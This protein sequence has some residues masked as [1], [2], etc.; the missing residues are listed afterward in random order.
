MKADIIHISGFDTYNSHDSGNYIVF[1]F[2]RQLK[3][4]SKMILALQKSKPDLDTFHVQK[5][6]IINTIEECKILFLHDELLSMEEIEQIYKKTKCKIIFY[7]QTHYHISDTGVSGDFSYPDLNSD[8][9]N[10][11]NYDILSKKKSFIQRLPISV[12][13]GSS[14][15][16]NITE[17]SYLNLYEDKQV[18]LIPL[19]NDVPYCEI[20]K[21]LL[22]S[23]H[24]LSEKNKYVFWG[25]T[26][27]QTF[28]KG[29][30]YFDDAMKQLFD[31]LTPEQRTN[32][33]II[34]AGPTPS[35]EFAGGK[36]EV[37]CCG[38]IPSREIMSNLYKLSDISVCTTISDAGPMMISE[39]MCN[40]TPVIAFDRSIAI[41]LIEDQKTGFLIKDL[42]TKNM[43]ESIKKCLFESDIDVIS[44]NARQKFLEFHDR[45]KILNK[46]NN[47]FSNL[48][49]E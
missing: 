8:E 3:Y 21:S 41:D 5:N 4:D 28:R 45:E 34:N 44:K 48:S 33:K 32:I 31:L 14:H 23:K 18:Y 42:S 47:L 46:W 1:N 30:A 15:S 10:Q 29:K 43:A 27:P 25:T 37:I 20:D 36:Y 13:V 26:Q 38:Y 9:V 12:V 19:P 17:K 7:T 35:T 39:S 6:N 2:L 11:K 22:R 24:N 40:E 49:K 16:K